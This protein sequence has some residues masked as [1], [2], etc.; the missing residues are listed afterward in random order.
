MDSLINQTKQKK[1]KQ[2]NRSAVLSLPASK[3]GTH[4][5]KCKSS[6]LVDGPSFSLAYGADIGS[7]TRDAVWGSWSW[8]VGVPRAATFMIRM[9]SQVAKDQRIPKHP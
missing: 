4:C 5:L 3:F 2:T 6:H 1:L 7:G 9:L 8:R